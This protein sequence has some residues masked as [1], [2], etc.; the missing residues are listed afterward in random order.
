M[1]R[2]PAGSPWTAVVIVILGVA[3]I[4]GG[5]IFA[6]RSVAKKRYT[7][8]DK[9]RTEKKA[10]LD[11]MEALI[12]S[13]PQRETELGECVGTL[14]RYD[15]P[16]IDPATI[17]ADLV[18]LGFRE[19]A[20]D[21]LEARIIRDLAKLADESGCELVDYKPEPY[22]KRRVEQDPRETPAAKKDEKAKAEAEEAFQS[23]DEVKRTQIERDRAY[24]KRQ[25]ELSRFAS[26]T[27][28][29][30][31]VRGK[32]DAIQKFVCGLSRWP[33]GSGWAFPHMVVTTNLK[34][35]TVQRAGSDKLAPGTDP[36]LEA[37]LQSRLFT[38]NPL[39]FA[40]MTPAATAGA[41]PPPAQ[42]TTVPGRA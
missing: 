21:E 13:K 39:D 33:T 16:V 8:K 31:K 19:V 7:V 27:V 2:K 41:A 24:S 3:I 5:T 30:L 6:V 35:A 9:E 25:T 18:R 1:N 32:L 28:L 17:P 37:T 10:Q 4:C 12:A 26:V 38:V 20:V 29:G 22:Q 36:D 42:G 23:L 15:I 34:V 11:T 14:K 40:K